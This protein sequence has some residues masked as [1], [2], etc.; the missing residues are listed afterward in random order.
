ML[1][2]K[3]MKIRILD[4]DLEK[5]IYSLEKP[6]IGKV[7][8]AI[9]LLEKFGYKLS[10]PHSKK[11]SPKIFELRI[12]GQQ[13]VRIFYTFS[14]LETILLHGFIKKS[15]KTPSREIKAAIDKLKY[16]T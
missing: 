9:D 7:I 1:K 8:H 5:F 2:G 3:N 10:S 16:F 15:Q 6:T 14:K 13:E 4:K 12:R 11:I